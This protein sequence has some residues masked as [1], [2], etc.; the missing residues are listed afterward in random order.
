MRLKKKIS[1]I[2]LNKKKIKNLIRNNNY[3][4]KNLSYNAINE[5]Y[6]KI[7]A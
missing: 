6:N 5:K 2:L 4:T 1:Y 7:F 3:I